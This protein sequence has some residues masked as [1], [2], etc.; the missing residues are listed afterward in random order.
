[1]NADD[2]R[3]PR[4]D[5]AYQMPQGDRNAQADRWEEAGEDAP[6]EYGQ[7]SQESYPREVEYG[8]QEKRYDNKPPGRGYGDAGYGYGGQAGFGPSGGSDLSR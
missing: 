2:L 8:E 5:N 7:V 3:K 1:M 6:V 4:S